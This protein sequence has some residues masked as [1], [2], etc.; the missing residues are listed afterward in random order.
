MCKEVILHKVKKT[1]D[2]YVNFMFTQ[3]I[4]GYKARYCSYSTTTVKPHLSQI[5]IFAPTVGPPDFKV[6]TSS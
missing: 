1:P 6:E 5:R 4:G 3:Y 2:L